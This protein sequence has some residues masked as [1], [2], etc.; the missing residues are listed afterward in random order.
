V[1]DP[2]GEPAQPKH[3]QICGRFLRMTESGSKCVKWVYD[4]S[5]G[6]DDHE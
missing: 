1:P 4:D 6:Q 3:C 5:T 2:V